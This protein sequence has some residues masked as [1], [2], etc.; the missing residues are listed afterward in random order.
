MNRS[1]L[2][3]FLFVAVFSCKKTFTPPPDPDDNPPVQE[4]TSNLKNYTN[5]TI[6]IVNWNIEWF[7]SS[8][9]GGNL[10]VQE[11]NAVKILKF[12][13]A[14]FYGIC[15]VVDT[16]RFGNMIRKQ[17][18]TDYKYAISP[19]ANI[20]QKLVF[21]YNKHIFRNIHTR[22]FMG[23]SSNAYKNFASGRFP[24]LLTGN[25]VVNNTRQKFCA[26]LLHA[27]AY[28]TTDSYNN[29]LYASIEMKD[30]LDTYFQNQNFIVFGDFND[31]LNGSITPGKS[32]PYKNFVDDT[33]KYMAYT[34]P[35][36]TYGYSSTIN[37]SNSVIDQ[38]IGSAALSRYY[39]STS[40][41]IRTDVVDVVN[42][43]K[44]GNTSDHYPVSS[45][46]YFKN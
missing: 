39:V 9:F 23:L 24:F 13:N 34:L 37:Y 28:N 15:E 16:G 2:F 44:S 11:A 20:S 17:L 19:Y 45:Q 22:P 3:I 21:V 27:K 25:V 4:D 1:L 41:K 6:T 33:Q 5:K 10:N 29:R 32:S 12:L 30:S 18:G 40:A 7:G 38:Q 31:N 26:V 35:F 8:N 42:D 43:F 36:N 46:Y 14:D